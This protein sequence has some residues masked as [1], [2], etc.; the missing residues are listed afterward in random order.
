MSTSDAEESGAPVTLRDLLGALASDVTSARA[1][2]DAEA[3]RIARIYRADPLLRNLPVPLFR[4]ADLTISMPLAITAV[5]SVGEPPPVSLSLAASV[6]LALVLGELSDRGAKDGGEV[7]AGLARAIEG[8]RVRLEREPEAMREPVAVA[9]AFVGAALG[10]LT[11]VQRSLVGADEANAGLEQELR[12]AARAR[13]LALTPAPGV[14]IAATTADVEAVSPRDSLVQLQ[15]N[16][17]E[18]GVQWTIGEHADHLV[19]E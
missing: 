7:A 17:S 18:G 13:I 10:A 2:A 4:L 11:S 5:P 1:H 12:L 8:E 9:D 14:Q 15:V 6:V 16:L 3:M 19:P